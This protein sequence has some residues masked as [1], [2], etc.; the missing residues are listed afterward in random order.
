MKRLPT[1]MAL[2][3]LGLVGGPAVR[4]QEPARRFVPVTDALVR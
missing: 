4:A 3:A 1:M 2:A